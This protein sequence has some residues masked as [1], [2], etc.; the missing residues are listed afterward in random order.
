[1]SKNK[2]AVVVFV[3]VLFCVGCGGE[4][5]TT[6]NIAE[7]AFNEIWV[8]GKV[9][10]AEQYF[11][12]NYQGYYIGLGAQRGTEAV[13]KSFEVYHQGLSDLTYVVDRT[14]TA[15]DKTAIIW[16]ATAV[17]TGEL[18]GIEPTNNPVEI[19]G[20]SVYTVEDGLIVEGGQYW[21]TPEFLNQL[22]QLP[23]E[24]VDLVAYNS[25]EAQRTT[26]HALV[27][28]D[29]TLGRVN[30][31]YDPAQIAAIEK[32]GQFIAGHCEPEFVNPED[33]VALFAEDFVEHSTFEQFQSGTTFSAEN[34]TVIE[35]MNAVRNIF[36]STLTVN[37]M[38]AEGEFV[39]VLN[40]LDMTQ[41]LEIL[42]VNPTGEQVSFLS[43]RVEVMRVADGKIAEHW[44]ADDL[45][46]FYHLGV[47]HQ[48]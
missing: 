10:A 13:H 6:E 41:Q 4:S 26:G 1:M 7:T 23:T 38:F 8:A 42:G 33:L 24:V 22:K 15:F 31:V 17:H 46:A 37:D 3:V 30:E 39:V 32:V 9:D 20:I 40:S 36:P 12:P 5:T 44:G 27:G 16:H 21:H 45:G 29:E 47:A 18:F 34:E 14:V 2:F 48:E 11:S 28:L 43:Q 19:E 35:V 25:P